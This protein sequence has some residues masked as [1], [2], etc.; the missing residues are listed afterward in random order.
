M[1]MKR[2]IVKNG[3]IVLD[4]I[5]IKQCSQIDLKNINPGSPM[6]VVLHVDVDEVDI[7]YPTTQTE[8][9]S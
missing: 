1:G 2:L 5:K 9:H 7:R 3:E 6:E 4:G 8:S